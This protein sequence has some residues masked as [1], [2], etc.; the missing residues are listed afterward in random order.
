MKTFADNNKLNLNDKFAKV[1]MLYN[2]KN[3]NLQQIGFFLSHFSIYEQMIPYTGKNNSKQTI[4]T[5][6]IRFGDKNFVLTSSDGCP[7]FIGP[8]RGKKHGGGKDPKNLSAC[9]V[10]NCITEIVDWCNKEAYF[11]SWL[12]SFFFRLKL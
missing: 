9:S 2:I 4:S 8:Y 10:L 5:K 6:S 12:S 1:K 3:K 7:Y 11:D